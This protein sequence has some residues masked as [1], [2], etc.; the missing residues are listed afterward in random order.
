MKIA[1]LC[2]FLEFL[3]KLKTF[4]SGVCARKNC[5][6]DIRAKNLDI[7][8][9][10]REDEDWTWQDTWLCPHTVLRKF[11]RILRKS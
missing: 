8:Y 2:K 1:H 4:T 10:C 7:I 9:I 6:E 11:Y 5:K 3:Q